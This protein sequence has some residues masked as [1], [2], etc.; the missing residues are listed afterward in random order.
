MVAVQFGFGKVCDRGSTSLV[1]VGDAGAVVVRRERMGEGSWISVVVTVND[2][3]L[4]FWWWCSSS[5]NSG[6]EEVVEIESLWEKGPE[7][8]EEGVVG[9]ESV[10][11]GSEGVVGDVARGGVML[12]ILV[13]FGSV[14]RCLGVVL[15]FVGWICLS[16]GCVVLL[17]DGMLVVEMWY[18]G[19]R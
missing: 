10:V 7:K 2:G 1:V 12:G 8:V 4:V 6:E 3:I 5:S 11:G 16:V 15:C 9:V 19:R 14:W 13:R 18:Q 17:Q